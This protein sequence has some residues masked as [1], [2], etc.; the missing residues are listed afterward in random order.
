MDQWNGQQ[1]AFTIKM[2]Y[3]NNDSLEVAQKEFRRFFNLGCH[4]RVPSKQFS[5]ID[6]LDYCFLK[7]KL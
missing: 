2:F 1:R 3:K 6:N 5:D 4:G 7:G